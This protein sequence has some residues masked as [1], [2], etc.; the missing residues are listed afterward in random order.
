MNY[1]RPVLL[2]KSVDGL[3]ISP[4]GVYL[5]L[6]FGGG[7]HSKEILK[8]IKTGKLIAFDQDKDA[9]KNIIDSDNFIFVQAN[10]KYLSNFVRY[11]GFDKV[12]G[13]LADLGISSHHI[14]MPERGFSFRYDAVL[15]MRM[16]AE[17]ELSAYDVIN[18]YSDKDL[19]T[20]FRKYGEI[21]HPVRLVNKIIDA[22]KTTSVKTTFQLLDVIRDV[23]PKNKENKFFAQVFQAIRIEVNNEIK[24]LEQTL[25]QIDKVLRSG[26]RLSII[27]YHSLEDKLVKNFIKSGNV[28]GEI[29]K[30]NF[31]NID[32]RYKAVNKK[33]ITP[34]NE[35]VK[36][37][38]RARSAK[39]RIAEKL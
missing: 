22:R 28:K 10:F 18:S 3:N 33:I 4:S 17:A 30:D 14:D 15:D 25:T 19:F 29:H 31:G 21:K 26:G 36:E 7:G 27:S 24:V 37:N 39:L 20:I 13:V 9:A 6:T 38:N 11:Y 35:E 34:S 23:A 1:H 8:H 16:N 32:K 2:K 12:D 5:D